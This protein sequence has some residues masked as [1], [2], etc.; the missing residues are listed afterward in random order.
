[1]SRLEILE[2]STI[3]LLINDVSP[4]SATRERLKFAFGRAS[5]TSDTGASTVA[6][7]ERRLE[8]MLRRVLQCSPI[9]TYPFRLK[10]FNWDAERGTFAHGG[11]AQE[12][13]AKAT[14]VLGAKSP[15][16][17]RPLK[18]GVIDESDRLGWW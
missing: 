13:L 7:R 9:K 6:K 10:L 14:T 12:F 1:M 3:L 4:K 18:R 8:A 15:D 11:G 16:D 5:W 2:W 17:L